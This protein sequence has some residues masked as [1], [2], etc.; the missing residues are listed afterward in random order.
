MDLMFSFP[1]APVTASTASSA[2]DTSGNTPPG[3]APK[4]ATRRARYRWSSQ[5][6]DVRARLNRWLCPSHA[7]L[8]VYVGGGKTRE[9]PLLL[10][11]VNRVWQH[12]YRVELLAVDL[13]RPDDGVHFISDIRRH[14]GQ[15]NLNRISLHRVLRVRVGPGVLARLDRFLL[16]ECA[17]DAK[18]RTTTAPLQPGSKKCKK[19]AAAQESVRRACRDPLLG[20]VETGV[21][22]AQAIREA[23]EDAVCHVGEVIRCGRSIGGIEH[24]PLRKK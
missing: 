16:E 9:V 7:V 15:S 18:V 12:L 19:C 11:H 6:Q 5:P 1:Q 4:A 13:T 22:V 10:V 3:S 2:Q 24:G 17:A 14:H 8:K 20:G 21:L 23:C